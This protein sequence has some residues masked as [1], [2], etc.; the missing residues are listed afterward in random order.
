M[1]YECVLKIIRGNYFIFFNFQKAGLFKCVP[2][3][4]PKTCCGLIFLGSISRLCVHQAVQGMLHF[5]LI[6]RQVVFFPVCKGGGETC[7]L[8]ETALSFQLPFFSCFFDCS[9][10]C[11]LCLAAD[12]TEI[13][14]LHKTPKLCLEY[15]QQ[16]VFCSTET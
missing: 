1:I 15:K 10:D 12:S 5:L 3:V 14:I 13:S 2:N 7:V 6:D 8:W 4:H 16:P 9:F 11:K